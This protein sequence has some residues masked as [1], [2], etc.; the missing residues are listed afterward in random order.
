MFSKTAVRLVDDDHKEDV[1][2]LYDRTRKIQL[3]RYKDLDEAKDIRSGVQQMFFF[4]WNSDY[5]KESKESKDEKK[6]Q[7][8]SAIYRQLYPDQALRFAFTEDKPLYV[9]NLACKRSTSAVISG[10]D[11]FVVFDVWSALNLGREVAEEDMK[12]AVDILGKE[13]KISF[14]HRDKAVKV[15]II[16]SLRMMERVPTEKQ[17]IVIYDD[18]RLYLFVDN[19]NKCTPMVC[20]HK[21]LKYFD[22]LHEGARPEAARE[23]DELFD[24][25]DIEGPD[26]GIEIRRDNQT[27]L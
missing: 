7:H 25:L 9:F 4:N 20:A 22:I 2:V 12:K 16:T 23:R 8:L 21:A 14:Q 13:L 17:H 27:L 15:N 18:Q 24:A 6:Q 10:A 19:N 1:Y 26:H 3:G 5:V 11:V